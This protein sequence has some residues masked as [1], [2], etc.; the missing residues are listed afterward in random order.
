MH[1][2][3]VGAPFSSLIQHFS[4]EIYKL[5]TIYKSVYIH[6]VKL[7]GL[8]QDLQQFR[9]NIQ[10]YEPKDRVITQAD[11]NAYNEITDLIGTFTA[12]F[13][14]LSQANFLETLV[15]SKVDEASKVIA[16]FRD[17][18]NSLVIP[19][20]IIMT[21]PCPTHA[22]QEIIDAQADVHDLEAILPNAIKND[23]MLDSKDIEI[24]KQR[25][26]ELDFISNQLHNMEEIQRKKEDAQLAIVEQEKINEAFLELESFRFNHEDFEIQKKIGS[27]GFADVFLG[28]QKST[29]KIVAIKKLHS[30]K[31]TAHHFEMFK[32]EIKIE[33]SLKHFAILP[34]IG[35]VVEPP[36]YI[37]TEYMSGN[38]LF[39]R[40]HDRRNPLSPTKLTIIALGVAY[41][42]LHMHSLNM[43]HRDIKSLNIL[44]NADDYPMICDFGMSRS[45]CAGNDQ[46]TGGIGTAQWMAPE[47]M[48]S[49][50][51]TEK[52]DV[53]SYGIMLW[54][55][56]TSDYPFRGLRDVQVTVS[57]M[58]NDIRPIIPQDCP[59][60][61]SQ[62]IQKCWARE[63]ETRPNFATIVKAFESGKMDF[64]G[65]NRDDVVSYINQFQNR[66]EQVHDFDPE[67]TS[68]ES[69][70]T[71]LLQFKDPKTI[72]SAAE[73]LNM[74]VTNPQW[75][76]LLETS[77][78]I[79]IV[80][81]AAYN[82]T[83]SQLALNL[84]SIVSGIMKDKDYRKV[85]F[86]F[87]GGKSI[88]LL[89]TKFGTTSMTHAISILNEIVQNVSITFGQEQFVK[90]APFLVSN[91]MPV[92][93]ASV[94]L[95]KKIITKN[96]YQDENL[97]S[98]FVNNLLANL[99]AEGLE[100][101]LIEALE[102]LFL[103]SNFKE[104]FSFAVNN[105]NAAHCIFGLANHNNKNIAQRAIEL[106]YMMTSHSLPP[107]KTITFIIDEFSQI[108][109]LENYEI[110]V[111]ML[112]II[113]NLIKTPTAINKLITTEKAISSFQKCL[114]STNVRVLVNTL[115]LYCAFL[116]NKN[117]FNSFV[118]HA[119]DIV[120]LL[121]FND[122]CVVKLSAF[123]LIQVAA[124][125]ST[126]SYTDSLAN[127]LKSSLQNENKNLN[128]VLRLIG[129]IGSSVKG[130]SF[131]S[132]SGVVK[133]LF[134]YLESKD[135]N[136]VILVL[137]D[138][139][140]ISSSYPLSTELVK[141]IDSVYKLVSFPQ[142]L[143]YPLIFLA[144]IVIQPQA[145]VKCAPQISYFIDQLELTD[146][147][148]NLVRSFLAIE[149]I[150][151]VPEALQLIKETTIKNLVDIM[152]TYVKEEYHSSVYKI[153]DYLSASQ[154][155]RTAISSSNFPSVLFNSLNEMATSDPLRPSFIRIMSRCSLSLP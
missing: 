23:P 7:A 149:R 138:L 98:V 15:T 103:F 146:S 27:G 1:H 150:V 44:L 31:F 67:I 69:L 121:E 9:T 135:D 97:F 92:R 137:K 78:F 112:K 79:G 63:P 57:V 47:V 106:S 29:G 25:I 30:S 33:S 87:N 142:F 22:R 125:S 81:D 120:S 10:R 53:Y 111:V 62:L 99:I 102:V 153:L 68:S 54:E 140:T 91:E 65:T 56:L 48:A 52:A 60:K 42:L 13:V 21:D 34:F 116:E 37:V 154:P 113:S 16:D 84:I 58:Q 70:E 122:S 104:T 2:L 114:H 110:Q 18:F 124:T 76:T 109:E 3:Q 134:P 129:A 108:I 6:K 141:I 152:E 26:L 38:S 71:I 72:T 45:F 96:L 115:K 139:C 73:K 24:I 74:I 93:L 64:P 49:R 39:S 83:N 59:P 86:D 94:E 66:K 151:S 43:L 12:F 95:I 143:P 61:L 105:A 19:L 36:F 55:M 5:F 20:Q 133:Y 41:G 131:L 145:A 147:P 107:P 77:S 46:L 119:N 11:I 136:I 155:A 128:Y 28:Y 89:F 101:I 144:N 126:I 80:L 88:L 50:P 82:C 117:S 123:C 14:S 85:F 90:I 40:I 17:R 32:R 132:E 75:H 51:Y 118:C 130:A 148:D 127:F 35:I 100:P 4:A 8:C